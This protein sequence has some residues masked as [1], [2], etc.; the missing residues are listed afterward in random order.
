MATKTETK[1][2]YICDNCG[3][4]SGSPMKTIF[5]PAMSEAVCNHA[6]E[7]E[8]CADCLEEIERSLKV[9]RGL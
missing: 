4:E 2:I 3:C 6:W 5:G 7:A 9:K 1:T 8:L